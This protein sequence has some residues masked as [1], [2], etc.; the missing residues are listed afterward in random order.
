MDLLSGCQEH[1]FVLYVG[2]NGI[3]LLCYS[4]ISAQYTYNELHFT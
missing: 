2:S 3:H 4:N 1:L